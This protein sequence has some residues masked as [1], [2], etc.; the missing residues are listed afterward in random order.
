MIARA[1]KARKR[2]PRKAKLSAYPVAL[3]CVLL[4]IDPAACSGWALFLEGRP[5]TWGELAA[6]NSTGIDAVLLQACELAGRTK[7]PLV[8]LGEDWGRGGVLGL[9]QWQGLGGAWSAWKFG[10]ERAVEKGLAVV[11]SRI[12]RVQQSTWRSPFGL[13]SLGRDV[14]KAYSV[15]AA[16]NQ[17]GIKLALDQHDVAEALLIGLWGARA[18]EVGAKL[19]V[20]IMRARGLYREG[21]KS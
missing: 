1:P 2:A 18:G 15:R 21:T 6:S 17:L 3:P 13:A 9:S 4:A 19:P 14:V 5:V 7:L 8:V 10:C 12:L 20:K 11:P 16:F